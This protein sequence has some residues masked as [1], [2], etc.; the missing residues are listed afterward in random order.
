MDTKTERRHTDRKMETGTDTQMK[1]DIW[2]S[3]NNREI[4]GSNHFGYI[5]LQ[6]AS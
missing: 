2:G 5:K 1:H 6:F 3:F 4:D